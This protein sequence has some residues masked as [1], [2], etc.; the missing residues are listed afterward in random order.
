MV[1][2]VLRS[3]FSPLHAHSHATTMIFLHFQLVEL[4]FCFIFEKLFCFRVILGRFGT[5]S[6]PKWISYT[7]LGVAKM[8]FILLGLSS[9]KSSVARLAFFLFFFYVFSKRLKRTA[10]LMKVDN[11]KYIFNFVEM[12]AHPF[13]HIHYGY[14]VWTDVFTAHVYCGVAREWLK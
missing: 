9:V 14:W 11:R 3:L 8:E 5:A 1:R 4:F 10:L 2:P 7:S 12:R 6:A 13:T